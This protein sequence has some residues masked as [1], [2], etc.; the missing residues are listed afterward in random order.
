MG[1]LLMG[2][3]AL[4]GACATPGADTTLPA[5][6]AWINPGPHSVGFRSRWALDETRTYR[7]TWDKGATY[8]GQGAPRPVLVNMWYPA[9]ASGDGATMTH[10]NYFT[11]EPRDARLAL[12]AGALQ[13]FARDVFVQEFLGAPEQELNAEELAMLK[14]LLASPAGCRRGAEPAK[15]P[16][17]LLV[18]HSGAGSSYED[19]AQFCTYLASHGY[20]VVGS[21]FLAGDGESLQTDG[22]ESSVEDLR[23][24]IEHAS[25]L[26]FVDGDHVAVA[27]HSLG[28]QATMRY[29]AQPGS[30]A[31]VLILLDTTVDYYGLVIP[32]F[33]SVT[34]A[35]SPGVEHLTETILVA[36]ACPD[37]S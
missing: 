36:A 3:A 8:G 21:A 9:P 17:P 31:D 14:V 12:L 24:L 15:G 16:F 19:N 33:E 18:F 37:T 6:G 11:I 7:T 5:A 25:R 34:D 29:G 4:L 26:P 13:D 1:S 23:F 10:G 28:A 20:V 30:R 32:L 35:V 27:G 2:L 22:N